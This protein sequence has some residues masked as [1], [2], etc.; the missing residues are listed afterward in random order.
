MSEFF[1][2]LRN[3]DNPVVFFDFGIDNQ[4]TGKI[5]IELFA[6]TCPKVI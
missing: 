6:D 4:H 3:K 5:M 1:P 2:S